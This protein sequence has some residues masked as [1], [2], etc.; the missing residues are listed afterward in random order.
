V[1]WKENSGGRSERDAYPSSLCSSSQVKSRIWPNDEGCV[2]GTE[3]GALRLT[4]RHYLD[5][6]SPVEVVSWVSC[7]QL[8]LLD[9]A[10][11]PQPESIRSYCNLTMATFTSVPQTTSSQFK[12][13]DPMLLKRTKSKTKAKGTVNTTRKDNTEGATYNLGLQDKSI[14]C[15]LS[16]QSN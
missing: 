9:T 13:Y 16:M 10:L 1:S 3:D 12:H 2:G 4:K 15:P 14:V 11:F 8:K 7:F 5:V 6:F